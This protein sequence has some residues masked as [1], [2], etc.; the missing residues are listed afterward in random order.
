MT[1]LSGIFFTLSS[2]LIKDLEAVATMELLVLRSLIQVGVMLTIV[3]FLRRNPFGPP[4]YRLLLVLQ[5]FKKIQL[6]SLNFNF[7]HLGF[8]RRNNAGDAF[9]CVPTTASWRRHYHHFQLSSF[10]PPPLLHFPAGRMQVFANSHC[11]CARDRNCLC[12][13]AA[14]HFRAGKN[15]NF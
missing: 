3:A 4:G 1:I 14:V 15:C 7:L 6:M 10:R 12:C 13:A 5:V 2:A 8:F 11:V 9:Y